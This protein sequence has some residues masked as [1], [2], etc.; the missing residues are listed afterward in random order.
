[1]K[2]FLVLC[3]MTITFFSQGW[4]EKHYLVKTKDEGKHG[5]RPE[6]GGDYNDYGNED[7]DV[8]DD[9]LNA[10]DTY[11]DGDDAYDDDTNDDDNEEELDV[12]SMIEDNL[13]EDAVK[14]YE[15]LG[16]EGQD[17]A[18]E[19]IKDAAESRKAGK[20]E[21]FSMKLGILKQFLESTH[22]FLGAII[23]YLR[24]VDIPTLRRYTTCS[25]QI[26]CKRRC[27]KKCKERY[28]RSSQRSQKKNR[29]KKL[30]IKYRKIRT[31]K[32]DCY[33]NCKG[34]NYC[35]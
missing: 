31:C 17:E 6:A 27:R 9:P 26:N 28:S 29:S 2:V 5:P 18:I 8:Y 7:E 30:S 32:S 10:V 1:M 20:N 21:D 12:E 22:G 16:E 15:G 23:A 4:G 3:F 25:S 34:K 24:S 35:R 19:K 11:D 33:S 14:E 13:G